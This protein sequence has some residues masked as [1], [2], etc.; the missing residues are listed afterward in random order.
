M[1]GRR[2]KLTVKKMSLSADE[3]KIWYE[4]SAQ[5]RSHDGESRGSDFFEF[6]MICC[7]ETE[8]LPDDY[9]IG[10]VGQAID[11]EFDGQY[12]KPVASPPVQ[13]IGLTLD[14][15]CKCE[16]CGFWDDEKGMCTDDGSKKV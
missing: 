10:Q 9:E 14:C 6:E 5:V 7:I 4:G 8:D 11:I 16:K 2:G 15:D 12:W 13:N 1:E 3:S